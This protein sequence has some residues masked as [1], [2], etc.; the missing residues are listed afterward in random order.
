MYHAESRQSRRNSARCMTDS[1]AEKD[2]PD[3]DQR[4]FCNNT[5]RTTTTLLPLRRW[6]LQ[7]GRPGVMFARRRPSPASDA[8]Q[9]T[10]RVSKKPNK[11]ISMSK[12]TEARIRVDDQY[13]K[14]VR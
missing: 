6:S 11:S 10:S 4:P 3:R 2:F 9:K 7:Y 13:N 14:K 5:L 8:V 12:E 1:K